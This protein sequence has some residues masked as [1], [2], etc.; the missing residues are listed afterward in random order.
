LP[1]ST[2]DASPSVLP[3]LQPMFDWNLN[4]QKLKS[5]PNGLAIMVVIELSSLF[6]HL[7]KISELTIDHWEV[8]KLE[9]NF[10]F[11]MT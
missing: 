9:R 4:Q 6:V 2:L 5:S 7:L 8:G 11:R 3:A 1:L 10:D